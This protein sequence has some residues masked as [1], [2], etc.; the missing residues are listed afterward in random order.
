MTVTIAVWIYVRSSEDWGHNSVIE[1]LL[2]MF[3]ALSSISSAKKKKV[4][5]K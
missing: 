2:S 5:Y 3:T 4:K 1:Y